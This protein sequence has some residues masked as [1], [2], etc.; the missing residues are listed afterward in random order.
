MKKTVH[1]HPD[2]NVAVALQALAP[3]ETVQADDGIMIAITRLFVIYCLYRIEVSVKTDKHSPGLRIFIN[4][5]FEFQSVRR[6]NINGF[7]VCF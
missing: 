7:A 5:C 6:S 1:I 2:D 4:S 3:G